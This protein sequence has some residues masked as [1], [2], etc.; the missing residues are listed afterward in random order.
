MCTVRMKHTVVLSARRANVT[1]A[2][3][4]CG[5]VSGVVNVYLYVCGSVG[6]WVYG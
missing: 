4:A 1:A 5:C 2:M 3:R 6:A